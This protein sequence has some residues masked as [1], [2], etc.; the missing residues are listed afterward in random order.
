MSEPRENTGI[1]FRN[2]RKQSDA[3]PDYTGTL[4]VGGA[5][6]Q[7]SGWIKQGAKAKFMSLSVRPKNETKQP[8][9]TNAQRCD[10][11]IGF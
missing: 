6:Y 10:D 8:A 3:S 1:L 2:N 9:R 11:K 5:E 4:N 7:I